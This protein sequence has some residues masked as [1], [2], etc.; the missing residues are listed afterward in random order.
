M[1]VRW[2]RRTAVGF[3]LVGAAACSGGSNPSNSA[4]GSATAATLSS[5]AAHPCDLLTL[6]DV[7]KLEP[8]IQSGKVDTVGG[9]NKICDWGDSQGIPKVQLQVFAAPSGSLKEEMS[10]GLGAFGGYDFVDV[11]GLGNEAVAGFQQAD[12][13]K[14]LKAGLAS[15]EARKGNQVVDI[16]TPLG[17]PVQQG[18]ARFDIV[19]QLMAKALAGL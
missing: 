13:A 10:N 12:P 4:S 18:S 19:K 5:S 2:S 11:S 6:A 15:L 1:G 3:L 16:S 7:Q 17:T 8:S 14:G 9:G